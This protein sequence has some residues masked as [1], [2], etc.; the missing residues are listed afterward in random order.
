MAP[1]RVLL[2]E[3]DDAA[4]ELM[5]RVLEQLG[6]EVVSAEDGG[7]ML[8]ALTRQYKEGRSP[9]DV[10]LVVTDI[11]MPVV[12]GLDLV[13]GLRSAG[14]RT[15]V[16]VVTAFPTDDVKETVARIGGILLEK[17]INL[18]EFENA[19]RSALATKK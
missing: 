15:P 18:E 9:K 6:L 2:A 5:A 3:D 14:W 1:H 17:P 7:R 12:G 16:I 4:R 19:V 13:K 10:D 8:V 11:N